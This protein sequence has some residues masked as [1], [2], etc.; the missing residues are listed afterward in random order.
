MKKTIKK[1]MKI[2]KIVK[3]MCKLTENKMTVINIYKFLL[4]Q[5]E[6]EA[7]S[8]HY[9]HLT[10]WNQFC[11]MPDQA[12]TKQ[13]SQKITQSSKICKQAQKIL[14]FEQEEKIKQ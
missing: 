9:Q 6:D 4:F 8:K 1:D 7:N 13:D 11:F 2:S 10:S 5:R 3:A 12:S 14:D